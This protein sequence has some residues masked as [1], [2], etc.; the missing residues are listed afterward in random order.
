MGR[1]GRIWFL[2]GLGY[3]LLAV[4]LAV[5]AV[6]AD[7]PVAFAP[8]VLMGAPMTVLISELL[9][10]EAGVITGMA[11]IAIGILVNAVIFGA[12]AA[13]VARLFRQR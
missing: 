2:A 11:S 1:T 12:L 10:A 13:G 8:L 4:V 9:P 7:D 5:G 6:A 3:V